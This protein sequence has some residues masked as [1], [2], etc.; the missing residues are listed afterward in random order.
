[1]YASSSYKRVITDA[2]QLE[3]SKDLDREE[4]FINFGQVCLPPSHLLYTDAQTEHHP[5][6]MGSDQRNNFLRDA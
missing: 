4:L 6:G 2:L 1:N 3:K 5:Q